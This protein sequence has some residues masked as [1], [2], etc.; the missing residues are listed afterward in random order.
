MYISLSVHI[1]RGRGGCIACADLAPLL[2]VSLM[3]PPQIHTNRRIYII[4]KVGGNQHFIIVIT[5][6]NTH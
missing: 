3:A 2:Y 1:A 5:V 6:M 4:Y